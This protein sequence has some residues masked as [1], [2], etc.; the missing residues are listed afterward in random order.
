MMIHEIDVM[1][2]EQIVFLQDIITTDR[3]RPTIHRTTQDHTIAGPCQGLQNVE[4][5]ESHH[6]EIRTPHEN[7][8]TMT[9]TPP[10]IMEEALVVNLLEMSFWKESTLI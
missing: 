10:K 4:V 5:T 9:E 6:Q 8:I 7:Q 2:E 1:I 3:D